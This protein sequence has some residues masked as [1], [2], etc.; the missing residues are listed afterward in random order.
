MVV[1]DVA[2]HRVDQLGWQLGKQDCVTLCY[3]R[4]RCLPHWPYNLFCMVHGHNRREVLACIDRMI[5]GLDLNATAHAV[6]FSG[7]RF[8]QRGARYRGFH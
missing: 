8:K 1:W 2:D 6:L 5:D 3:R 7:K 4:P